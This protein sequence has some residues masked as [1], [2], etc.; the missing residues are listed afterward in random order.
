M[1]GKSQG[2]MFLKT[3]DDLLGK[4]EAVDALVV[5]NQFVIRWILGECLMREGALKW[6]GRRKA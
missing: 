2:T 6:G 4:C 1:N 5:K 3:D